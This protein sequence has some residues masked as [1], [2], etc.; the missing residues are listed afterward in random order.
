MTARQS[1]DLRRSDTRQRQRM[2]TVR[3]P[4]G[5]N[6]DGPSRLTSS[7]GTCGDDDKLVGMAYRSIKS[8]TRPDMVMSSEHR[9]TAAASNSVK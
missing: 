2:L 3:F 9:A 5:Y 7:Y 6:D 8:R 4:V 1:R